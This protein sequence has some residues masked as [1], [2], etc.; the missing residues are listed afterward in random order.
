MTSHYI[1]TVEIYS[2]KT[3]VLLLRKNYKSPFKQKV[4][5]PNYYASKDQLLIKT[6]VLENSFNTEKNLS[7]AWIDYRKAFEGVP[8]SYILKSLNICKLSLAVISFIKQSTSIWKTTLQYS[9][10]IFNCNINDI[11]RL[12]SKT[13]KLLRITCTIQW[14]Y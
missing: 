5:K 9:F 6:T 10:K 11:R 7:T 4:W 13:R 3:N 14:L 2:D 12:Y 1:Q 8:H